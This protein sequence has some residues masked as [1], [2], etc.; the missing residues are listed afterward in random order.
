MPHQAV[1]RVLHTGRHHVVAFEVSQ[2][3]QGDAQRGS[4]RSSHTKSQNLHRHGTVALSTV[5]AGVTGKDIGH[6]LGRQ[7]VGV[8][9]RHCHGFGS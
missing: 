2:S 6:R 8:G 3:L 1:R 5:D 7:V 9:Q 4:S